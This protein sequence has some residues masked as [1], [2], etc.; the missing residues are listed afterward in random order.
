MRTCAF[1]T[2]DDLAGY[3]TDDALAEAPLAKLGWSGRSISPAWIQAPT[4]SWS[5]N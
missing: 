2:T 4:R 1:L 3:V 5:W